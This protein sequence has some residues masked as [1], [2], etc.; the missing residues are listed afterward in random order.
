MHSNII[1]YTNIIRENKGTKFKRQIHSAILFVPYTI[2]TN[3]TKQISVF[4]SCISMLQEKGIRFLVVICKTDEIC[5]GIRKSPTAYYEDL[6]TIKQLAVKTFRIREEYIFFCINYTT[7]SK[8]NFEIDKGTYSII[9]KAA[10]F[11]SR[12]AISL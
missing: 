2:F 11:A 10:E 3:N 9:S 12:Q 7:E 5:T 4:Y 1:Q 6:N 8:R